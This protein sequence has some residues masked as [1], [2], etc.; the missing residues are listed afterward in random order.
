MGVGGGGGGIFELQEFFSLSNSL[1][2]FILGRSMNI[3][4][5]LIVV[6]EI[7]FT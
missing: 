3:F 1:Y 6:H 5:G 4:Q 7:F 2:E